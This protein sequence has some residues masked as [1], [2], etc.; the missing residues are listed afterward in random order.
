MSIKCVFLISLYFVA[1][2]MNLRV[3]SVHDVKIYEQKELED[4]FQEYQEKYDKHYT[5][6]EEYHKRFKV[7]TQ[8]RSYYF[9]LP[10]YIVILIHLNT[11][12]GR[13]I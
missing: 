1:F 7:I 5:C 3:H 10:V 11:R 13:F 8:K 9:L 2:T 6:E 4:I 12:L